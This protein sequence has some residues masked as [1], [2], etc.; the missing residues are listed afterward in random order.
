MTTGLLGELQAGPA[1]R[2]QVPNAFLYLRFLY[3]ISHMELAA[4]HVPDMAFGSPCPG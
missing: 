2:L 4:W 1:A 3:L